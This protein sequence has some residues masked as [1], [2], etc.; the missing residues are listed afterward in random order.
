MRIADRHCTFCDLIHG[1]GEVSICYEDGDAIAFMDVQPVNAG[2]VLVVP[3]RH[4]ERIE[5][6]PGELAAHLFRVAG[7]LAPVVKQVANAEGLN[8]V[9]NS[10]AAAGQDEPHFH[11]HVIPRCAGDGFDVPLPFAGS[12]MPDRTVLDATAVR[13]MTELRDPIAA[14]Q[15][16]GIEA[17][18]PEAEPVRPNLCAS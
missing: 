3:R 2:H 7:R 6:V 11:V 13:I 10:G 16:V 8:I 18:A 15:R 1:A 5:D 17:S 9:V 12:S 4:L 14:I